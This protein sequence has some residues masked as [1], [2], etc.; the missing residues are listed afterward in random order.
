MFQVYLRDE[1][2]PKMASD[3]KLFK[4]FD[5]FW[6]LTQVRTAVFLP[7]KLCLKLWPLFLHDIKFET[8]LRSYAMSQ[9]NFLLIFFHPNRVRIYM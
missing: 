3:L 2:A 1:S 7:Q 8:I 6:I 5:T 9:T 4:I